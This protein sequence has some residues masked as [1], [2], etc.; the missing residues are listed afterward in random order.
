MVRAVCLPFLVQWSISIFRIGPPQLNQNDFST[1]GQKKNPPGFAH[2]NRSKTKINCI[3]R[4]I[5]IYQ[6]ATSLFEV[7][8]NRADK[9][10]TRD[11][12]TNAV[13]NSLCSTACGADLYLWPE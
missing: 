4:S 7:L 13:K 2:S 11:S 10:K 3:S 9:E 8:E 1:C 6:R 12:K 5:P